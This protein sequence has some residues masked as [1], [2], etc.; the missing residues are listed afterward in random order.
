M[1]SVEE[2]KDRLDHIINIARVQWYKPIQIA[3]VLYKSRLNTPNVDTRLLETYRIKSRRWRDEV[4]SK[5]LQKQK[6]GSTSSS[7][8]QDNVWDANAM[9]PELLA[10]LDQEN[11][12]NNGAVE[13]YIYLRF[14]ATQEAVAGI[15]TIVNSADPH[16]FDVASLFQAF[17]S[18]AVRRSIDKVYEVV[19]YSLMETIVV[20]LYA[21]ITVSVPENNA[22]MLLEFSDLSS[23]LLGL[24][25][26]KLEHTMPAHV[27]RVGITN[28]ADRGLDMWA[29]F[30]PV[31]QV[32]HMSLNPKLARD[33][34]DQVE[35]DN[36]IVVCTVVEKET[37]E[38]VLKQTSWMR[39][40]RDIVT[41][42]KLVEWYTR[43]L[44]GKHSDLL[45][46][47]LLDR[48][49][50]EL[51]REFSQA[52]GVVDFLNERNYM[53]VSSPT[54]WNVDLLQNIQESEETQ[55]LEYEHNSH[56]SQMI[57]EYL[58]NQNE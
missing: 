14:Q 58:E 5:F 41:Q 34:V 44:R 10:V 40:V 57:Y 30:G 36:I 56:N 1:S 4:C 38:T 31:I 21:Q 32:K 19:V 8:Y 9:T 42:E 25:P 53:T 23:I 29:N 6:A 50:T 48:L 16:T 11:K 54:I 18:Q 45:A 49:S 24:S 35:S 47:K 55:E 26:G 51:K 46:Q 52:A 17:Q 22:T 33:I 13:K 15:I 20:E 2:A 37:I 39:R 43:C 12:K 7:R 28:A 27:Y 3:E